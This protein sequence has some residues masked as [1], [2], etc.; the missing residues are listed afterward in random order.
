[1]RRL[2]LFVVSLAF[3][4]TILGRSGYAHSHD[5]LGTVQPNLHSLYMEINRA[6]FAGKLPDVPVT[7]GDLTKDAAYGITHFDKDVPYAMEI[8]RQSVHT[9]SFARDVIRHESCHIATIREAKRL[10]EDQH[11]ATFNTCMAQIQDSETA[12]D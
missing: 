2:V 12:A 6:S 7:W 5:V 9:E 4:G 3:L 11:G 1:M 8:D 10:H